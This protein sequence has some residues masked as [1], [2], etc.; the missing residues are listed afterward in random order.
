M[1]QYRQIR[2]RIQTQLGV[3]RQNKSLI[4]A[5]DMDGWK[6]ARCG[7]LTLSPV[8]K[9]KPVLLETSRG[10]LFPSRS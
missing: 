10:C 2:N 9:K 6:G 7:P 4:D 3:I 8:K 1:K 5:Y